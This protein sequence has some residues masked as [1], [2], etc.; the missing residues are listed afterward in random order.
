M[1]PFYLPVLLFISLL[2]SPIMAVEEKLEKRVEN[3]L[4]EAF[5]PQ[6][7]ISEVAK[8]ANNQ[9]LE[10][11]LF[12]GSIIH[13]TPDMNFLLNRDE[14]YSLAAR[15]PKNLTQARANP[16]RQKQLAALKAGDAIVFPAKGKKK[17]HIYVFTDVDCGYC[18]KLHEEMSEIN[19]LGIEVRYLAYPRAGVSNPQTGSY[20]DSYKKLNYAWCAKDRKKAMTSVKKLQQQL[21]RASMA[22]RRNNPSDA[23]KAAYNK[24]NQQMEEMLNKQANCNAPIEKEL[25]LGQKLGVRGTPAIISEN[26]ELYPGYLPAKQLARRLGLK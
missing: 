14:I 17:T 23:Q 11:I 18:Q 25:I 4:V 6:I 15:E 9:L 26:G 19:K 21:G 24:L 7:R 12:D 20:T 3:A 8:V 2:S 22:L 1:K 16:R 13:M 5:G 10:V